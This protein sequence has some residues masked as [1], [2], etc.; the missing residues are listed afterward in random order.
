LRAAAAKSLAALPK[1]NTDTN[2]DVETGR[3]R[4]PLRATAAKSLAALPLAPGIA[5]ALVVSALAGEF[6]VSPTGNDANPGTKE[7]PFATLEYARDAA[8]LVKGSTVILAP[9][10]YRMTKTLALDDRDSGTRF[11]GNGNARLTGSLEIPSGAVKPV[12]DPGILRRMLPEVR[13]KVLEI[14]LHALGIADFGEI[15]PRGFG[16]PYLPAP[17]ELFVD[18]EPLALAQWPKPGDPGVPIGRVLDKGAGC[19][20]NSPARGVTFKVATD[21]PARWTQADNVWITGFFCNGYADDTLKVK[22]FDVA[23]KTLTTVQLHGYGFTS[24]KPWNRWVALNLLEELSLPGEFMVDGKTGRLFFLA[25]E[26]KDISKCLL[27]VSMMQEP[28]VA[29]VGATGVV[30]DGVNVECSRG[31][32]VYIERGANNRIQNATLRNLGL[33]AVRIGRNG[34]G[35]AGK[36]QG[37]LNCRIYNIGAGAV[38]LG[39]GDRKR[40]TAGG[41]FVQNCEIHDFNRWD[42][43]YKSAVNIEGC[44][45]IVRHCLIYDCPGSAFYL[46]GNDHLIEYNEIHH[47]IMSGDDMGAF[48]MG[49]DPTERGT[50]IRYNYWHDLAP[51]RN[52]HCLYLD[53]A[54]GDGTTIYGNVFSKAG[55]LATV[56]IRHGSDIT[57]TNN[58]FIE[59]KMPL[60]MGGGS[61][62]RTK[63]GRFEALLKSVG[64]DQSPWRE[65]YPELLDYLAARPQMPRRNLFARNLLVNC[66]VTPPNGIECRDNLSVTNNPGMTDV[67]IPGFQPIPFDKIGLEKKP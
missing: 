23:K 24:D 11:V 52:T 43:T 41:N 14:D 31:I 27:E 32:G 25:P 60:R 35:E 4:R 55:G 26:G 12:T 44:G 15:G 45:N 10:T 48:Y 3:A 66:T 6:H 13:G 57:V 36:D 9:G 39:G 21:R 19:N 51:L 61:E 7:K 42:R 29:L 46:H 56:N 62:W 2:T 20:G 64:Y 50:V 1:R 30:F 65:R 17:L 58:I 63:D 54:G 49:R 18:D 38:V 53:D 37:I 59:C 22:S 8:R 28:V 67:G 33:L 16:R 40:L 5:V 47:A 34:N